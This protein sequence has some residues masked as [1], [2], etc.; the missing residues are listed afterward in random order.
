MYLLV[1]SNRKIPSETLYNIYLIVPKLN[2][3]LAET[4]NTNAGEWTGNDI[5]EV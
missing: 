2:K 3:N 5:A 1:L 4:F